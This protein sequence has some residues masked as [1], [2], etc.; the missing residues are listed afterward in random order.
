MQVSPRQGPA[1]RQQFLVWPSVGLLNIEID[2]LTVL[3]EVQN[4]VRYDY[5]GLSGT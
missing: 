5:A 1:D 3:I 2:T 4:K